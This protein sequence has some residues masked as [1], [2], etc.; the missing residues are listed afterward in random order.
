M[1]TDSGGNLKPPWPNITSPQDPKHLEKIYNQDEIYLYI[2]DQANSTTVKDAF[3][4]TIYKEL[5]KYIPQTKHIKRI[6]PGIYQIV[7]NK[8]DRADVLKINKVNN[9]PIKITENTKRNYAKGTIYCDYIKDY[10]DDNQLTKD[11]KDYND[12]IVDAKIKKIYKNSEQTNSNIAIITFDQPSIP[13]LFKIKLFYEILS[14]RQYY[15]DPQQCKKCFT[16]GHISTKTYPCN[17]DKICGYCAKNYHVKLDSTGKPQKCKNP[18]KCLNCNGPHPAWDRK[19]TKYLEQINYI[20]Y[21]V[22]NKISLKSA[23]EIIKKNRDSLKKSQNLPPTSEK[24]LSEKIEN[25]TNQISKQIKILCEL[26]TDHI[27]K[28][29]MPIKNGKRRIDNSDTPSTNQMSPAQGDPKTVLN[30]SDEM[31]QMDHTPISQLPPPIISDTSPPPLQPHSSS[32]YSG[33]VS[34]GAFYNDPNF[35]QLTKSSHIQH[36]RPPNS[37]PPLQ[38]CKYK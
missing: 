22:E 9:Y 14:V 29:N 23:I 37:I 33:Y 28:P 30:W 26:I 1:S 17:H 25:F 15:P 3:P 11:L 10:N 8:K 6:K 7:I 34:D 12:N 4:P 31:E 20:K 38:N 2:E 5:P 27:I 21:S 18:P 35:R 24:T 13:P 32:N 36:P 19:C 16:F